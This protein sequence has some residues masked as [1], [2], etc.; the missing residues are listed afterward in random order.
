M[1]GT[2]TTSMH[3]R[4]RRAEA[5]SQLLVNAK[6][7]NAQV[8]PHWIAGRDEFWYERATV[9]GREFRLVDC[10]ALTDRTAFDHGR[11][12][13]ALRAALAPEQPDLSELNLPISRVGVDAGGAAV[14]FKA[15]G[16]SWRYRTAEDVLE[17]VEDPPGT[18]G[19]LSPD[20]RWLAFV[21]DCNLWV[22]DLESGGERA[23]TTDG[24]RYFPYGLAPNAKVHLKL[25]SGA[26]LVPQVV[27]SADSKRLLA[28]RI[29]E[30][31]VRH[32]VL[33]DHA[34][35][36]GTVH[37]GRKEFRF[38]V[39]GDQH[40]PQAEIHALH[41]ETGKSVRAR[42]PGI[43]IGRMLDA[44]VDVGLAWFSQDAR[45]G[46]FVDVERGEKR[47]RV[48]AFDVDT[49]DCRIVFT[50]CSET[51][52]ELGASVYTRTNVHP[53]V[54]S[55]ELI[56]PSERTG[57]MHL[58]LYDLASGELR[59]AITE[60]PWRVRDVIHVDAARREVW[61]SASA[62]PGAPD[63]YSRVIC[64]SS[65]DGGTPV[66]LAS[67]PGDHDC[68][69][70]SDFGRLILEAFG[71]NMDG[72]C[73]VAPSGNFA[74]DTCGSLTSA[75]ASVLRDRDGNSRLEL[76]VADLSAMPA[77]WQWPEPFEAPAAD[78]QTPL[79]GVLFKPS[80]FE[81]G[82][83]Y[84]VIDFIYGGPQ[85]AHVPRSLMRNLVEAGAFV[86]AS[87]LAELGFIVV[88][89][90]GR[91]TALRD[92][93]FHAHSHGAVHRSSDVDD[94][95]AVLQQLARRH[96]F[97]DADRVGITGFS[98]GGF[99]T[100]HAMLA[101]PDFFKV[102][103]ASS[104]NYDQR[105]FWHGWGERYHGLLEGDNYESQSL[106]RLADRLQGKLMFTH[107]LLDS[108]CP[109]SA[110]FQLTQALSDANKDFDLVLDPRL[111]HERSSYATRRAWDYFVRHLS[112]AEPP[113]D[114]AIKTG[115][116]LLVE[117]LM[118]RAKAGH[119]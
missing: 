87:S 9:P 96:A 8:L 90:D 78:G 88:I 81:P 67:G 70:P 85:V 27:W 39:P 83:R 114:I 6:V 51:Y 50:E 71:T 13:I 34:P 41:L 35:A 58:Y 106:T 84:P 97:I 73:G 1:S 2:D 17:K 20:G 117:Q 12:A 110:L 92:R 105:L 38:A 10:A 65:I 118:S 72:V 40:V 111:A 62:W 55:G 94:H 18:K 108:G 31:M 32:H 22:R 33:V 101:R 69:S 59:G 43:P 98:G 91:G 74:V 3:D 89:V 11:L 19:A 66:L 95:V 75:P 5:L 57:Q 100:A 76:A 47:A 77:G 93:A 4:Y 104:G 25:E 23:L 24:E 82:R 107:G 86:D 56:W 26:D 113:S 80:D 68:I 61:Y 64:R 45:T 15:F 103:V 37:P 46:Y 99:A 119:V 48:V 79:H 102:G 36:N 109:V 21:R 63:P 30:R 29:D 42:Y 116:T 28:V 60:G 49:G 7:R 54:Q 52:L 112:T 53:V 14:G 16:K 44:L 115:S